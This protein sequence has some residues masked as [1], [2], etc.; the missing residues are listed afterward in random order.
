MIK[1]SSK[2]RPLAKSPF[3]GLATQPRPEVHGGFG[4]LG[5]KEN[6]ASA[7][8]RRS[9]GAKLADGIDSLPN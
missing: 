3:S 1:A 9:R 7:R 8:R 4:V 2:R 6:D 5:M